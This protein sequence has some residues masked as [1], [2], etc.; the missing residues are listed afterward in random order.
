MSSQGPKATS[1]RFRPRVPLDQRKRTVKACT[2][3]RLRKRRCVLVSPDRCQNCNKIN[4]SCTFEEEKED[5][6]VASTTSHSSRDGVNHEDAVAKFKRLHPEID[7][8]PNHSV[9]LMEIFKDSN[10]GSGAEQFSRKKR[11]ATATRSNPRTLERYDALAHGDFLASAT[12]A[13]SQTERP[14]FFDYISS[15]YPTL[16][17]STEYDDFLIAQILKDFPTHEE[18]EVL[19][20][21]FFT[22]AEANWYYFDRTTFCS[23]LSALF[24]SG[25]AVSVADPKFICLATAVFAL[26]SQFAHLHDDHSSGA[27]K[28]NIEQTGIPGAR[29]FSHAQRLIPRIITCPALEGVLSCLLIALY[30][31]P[32]HNPNI[33]YTYLGLALR[34]AICLGLHRRSVDNGLPPPVLETRNR[35]FWTTYSIERRI[36]IS[37]GYPE[38]LQEKDIDCALPRWQA[39]LD[40]PGSWQAERLLAYT[41]LT[42]LLNKSAQSRPLDK[43]ATEEIRSQLL[44]WK[45]ELPAQLTTLDTTTVRVNA[46]LQLHYCMVWTQI[47]RGSLISRVR[48]VLSKERAH[49]EDISTSPEAE[50]L[51]RLC[52]GHAERIID[53]IDLLRNR[54][55]LSRFS[56][57]DFHSCS[58]ATMIILLESILHPRLTSHTRVSRA[59]DALHFMACGSDFARSILKHVDMFQAAVNKALATMLHQ[60]GSYIDDH[61]GIDGTKMPIS[62]SRFEQL[63]ARDEGLQCLGNTHPRYDTPPIDRHSQEPDRELANYQGFGG[64]FLEDIGALIEECSSTDLHILG[65]DGLFG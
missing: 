46:H 42:L 1:K 62:T 28:P 44:A 51:S 2:S 35:A 49:T 56:H 34:V 23:Q 57:T 7:L 24:A 33:C 40:P 36:A 39:D 16:E 10:Q 50:E 6:P 9:V 53:L 52:V 4:S 8:K 21:A 41:K 29:F 65:F 63:Q 20:S 14:D 11:I 5:A 59:M 64:V 54:R 43:H 22:Y 19:I 17:A 25:L 27:E 32:I 18:A 55:L 37:L 48:S 45:N 13:V 58:S 60:G 15:F 61:G 3:C 31:L 30:A 47:S 12:E 38:M 26:G